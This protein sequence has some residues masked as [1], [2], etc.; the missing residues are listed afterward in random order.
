MESLLKIT[1]RRSG[2]SRP[3]KHK[4]TLKALGLTKLHRTVEVRDNPAIR[5]MVRQVSHLVE[6]VE[7]E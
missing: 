6:V 7:D 3:A 5:G 2:I 4:A 1:L